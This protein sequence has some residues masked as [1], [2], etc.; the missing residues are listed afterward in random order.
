[1]LDFPWLRHH[2]AF[3][4]YEKILLKCWL[5]TS[6]T[7]HVL[8]AQSAPESRWVKSPG[9]ALMNNFPLSLISVKESAEYG[10][11][12]YSSIRAEEMSSILLFWSAEG[13][14][15]K[16]MTFDGLRMK[17]KHLWRLNLPPYAACGIPLPSTPCF[18]R[19]GADE[20]KQWFGP[21]NVRSLPGKRAVG[22][23]YCE[24]EDRVA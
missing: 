12:S 5:R 17:N 20:S 22:G 15:V 24:S 21:A 3:V 4:L 18:N 14:T 16:N 9:S 13:C 1:M 2:S 19:S 8:K 11:S 23:R 6:C 10:V 7:R